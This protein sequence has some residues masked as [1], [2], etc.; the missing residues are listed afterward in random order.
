M[1][2]ILRS[3]AFADWVSMSA[4]GIVIWLIGLFNQSERHPI[5]I[6]RWLGLLSGKLRGDSRKVDLYNFTGQMVGL[7]IFGLATMLVIA[8]PSHADRVL[9]YRW[10]ILVVALLGALFVSVRRLII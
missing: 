10:G 4:F 7:L 3:E 8:V 1:N 2:E 9:W 6:P 5:Q